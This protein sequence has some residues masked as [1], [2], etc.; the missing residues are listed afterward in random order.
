MK[1][2]HF[3]IIILFLTWTGHHAVNAQNRGIRT[4]VSVSTFSRTGNL[5]DNDHMHLGFTAAAFRAIPIGTQLNLLPEIT[6]I[7]K[8][9]TKTPHIPGYPTGADYNICY[10]QIP[11]QLQYVNR[12]IVKA[13]G[14]Q[15]HFNGGPFAAFAFRDKIS[16]E[17]QDKQLAQAQEPEKRENDYGVSFGMG[18][19]RP[20]AGQVLSFDLKYDMGLSELANQPDDYRTKALSFTLGWAF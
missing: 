10:W 20:L 3:Y 7:Q 13:N 11:L 4:G 6:Y 2:I 19:Q 5:Y 17:G 12:E 14:A 8:G 18:Y 16:A 1:T 15:I 9:R